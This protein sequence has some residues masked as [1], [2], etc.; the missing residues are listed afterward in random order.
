MHKAFVVQSLISRSPRATREDLETQPFS[1]RAPSTW[2]WSAHSSC[3]KNHSPPLVVTRIRDRPKYRSPWSDP[4]RNPRTRTLSRRT[5]VRTR[6]KTHTSPSGYSRPECGF[7][8][9]NNS[10][11]HPPTT[12]ERLRERARPLFSSRAPRPPPAR[13]TRA[14]FHRPF[15]SPRPRRRAR[16]P[17]RPARFSIHRVSLFFSSSPSRRRPSRA[18]DAPPRRRPCPPMNR[19]P[20]VRLV[21]RALERGPRGRARGRARDRA[22]A[23]ARGRRSTVVPR[24]G[25]ASIVTRRIVAR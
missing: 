23:R 2:P 1:P 21:S 13:A 22:R 14:P 16:T 5:R 6:R 12:R 9:T 24:R 4:S 25:M 19:L 17:S 3:D 11:N 8:A 20:R 10:V 7:R 15:R 18:F